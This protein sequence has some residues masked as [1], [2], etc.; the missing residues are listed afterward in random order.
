MTDDTPVAPAH[1]HSAESPPAGLESRLRS[2]AAH[3]DAPMPDEIELQR[4]A[5]GR[6][7]R[8]MASAGVAVALFAGAAGLGAVTM[9]DND[10]DGE[11]VQVAS[12]DLD[13][14]DSDTAATTE[15]GSGRASELEFGTLP[16]DASFV[17]LP[18]HIMP[19]DLRYDG[20]YLYAPGESGWVHRTTDLLSWEPVPKPPVEEL[21]GLDTDAHEI[22][23]DQVVARGNVIA[24]IVH[25]WT[26]VPG[27]FA[28]VPG[29]AGDDEWFDYCGYAEPDVEGQ[30]MFSLDAGATWTV[31]SLPSAPDDD[32]SKWVQSGTQHQ[33]QTD[34][35][36]VLVSESA[37]RHFDIECALTD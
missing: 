3:I 12:P 18:D 2:N 33:I 29:S 1:P 4:R 15:S 10:G 8:T 27:S 19:W 21:L 16:L 25:D 28:A 31:T 36:S 17:E 11:R 22:G 26:S 37:F 32:V 23:F 13:A 14:S 7:R 24:T 9:L 20:Q 35:T 6:K 30:L 5:T 34:G